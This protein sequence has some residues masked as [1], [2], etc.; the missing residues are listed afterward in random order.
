[1]AARLA[2]TTPSLQMHCFALRLAIRTGSYSFRRTLS[3]PSTLRALANEN[4]RRYG[5]RI[6]LVTSTLLAWLCWMMFARVGVYAATGDARVETAAAAQPIESLVTARLEALPIEVGQHVTKGQVLAVLDSRQEALE[7]EQQSGELA[8]LRAQLVSLERQ[9]AGA[10]SGLKPLQETS[11]GALEQ[12]KARLRAARAAARLASEEAQRANK[13]F[14]AGTLSQAELRRSLS[15][16]AQERLNAAAIA[17]EVSGN[18]A[19]VKSSEFGNVR[20][21]EE[22]RQALAV[23]RGQV[24]SAEAS[25]RRLDLEIE[26]RTIRSSIA[27]RVAEVRALSVGQV[28]SKDTKLGVI[29]P[30]GRLIVVAHFSPS[31]ALGRIRVGQSASLRLEAFAWT[32]FG[33]VKAAVNQV[34][35]EVRDGLVRVELEIKQ[36][37]QSDIVLEHGLPGSIEIQIE[38]V[39]PYVLALRAAGMAIRSQSRAK[40]SQ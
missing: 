15:L 19:T 35:S 9:L 5:V 16:A 32:Q 14:A 28:V 11:L 17:R 33:T 26:T 7:R 10:L 36:D 24:S 39:A 37:K 23:L 29:V 40:A 12:S 6:A 31:E 27:G 34:T 25:M 13:L 38:R 30:E 1:M 3:F 2:R 20:D 8:S 18:E 21:V 4:F 22:L